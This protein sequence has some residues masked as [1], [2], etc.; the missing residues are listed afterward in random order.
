MLSKEDLAN[1]GQDWNHPG[2]HWDLSIFNT[3]PNLLRSISILDID[4]YFDL[5][6]KRYGLV[7]VDLDQH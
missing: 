3:E 6:P 7:R 4:T 1:L 2:W 5:Y